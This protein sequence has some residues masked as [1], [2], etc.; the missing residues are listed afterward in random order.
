M[1]S[2][3]DNSKYEEIAQRKNTHD[4]YLKSLF[5]ENSPRREPRF[6]NTII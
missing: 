1:F 2:Q 4:G 6:K 5:H 3:R